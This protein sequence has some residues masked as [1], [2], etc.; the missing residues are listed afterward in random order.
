MEDIRVLLID[1]EEE[2]TSA[3]AERLNLRGFLTT[4]SSR[5]EEAL[6]MIESDP[7]QVVVLDMRMPGLSGKEILARIKTGHPGIGIILLTGQSTVEI[8]K[9]GSGWESCDYLMKPVNIDDLIVKIRA[10][11]AHK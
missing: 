6:K 10:A 8:E 3:L 4:T 9:P 7:P 2:F 1:D 11:A 5:G